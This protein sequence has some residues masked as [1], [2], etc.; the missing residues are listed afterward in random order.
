MKKSFE[1]TIGKQWMDRDGWR[2]V[3]VNISELAGARSILRV[4]IEQ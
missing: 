2:S 4:A 1:M 3:E